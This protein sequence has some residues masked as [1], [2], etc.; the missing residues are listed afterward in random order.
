MVLRRR[1][2]RPGR[3]GA[4]PRHGRVRHGTAHV[5]RG[6]AT[7]RGPSPPSCWSGA[8]GSTPSAP[9]SSVGSAGRT[10]SPSSCTTGRSTSRRCS[11]PTGPAPSLSTSTSTT[12]PAEISALLADV[13]VKA[14]VYHRRYGPLV[15]MAIAGARRVVLIDVDDGSG[16][17]PL[18][19]S[20]DF[21]EL[22]SHPGR[23]GPA[24]DL[25]RRSLPGLH[26]RDHGTAQGGALAPGRHLRLGDG[27]G[28]GCHRRDDRRGGHHRDGLGPS[29]V[30]GGAADA[31]GG[32]VDRLLRTEPGRHRGACTTTA[33][34]SMRGPSSSWPSVSRWR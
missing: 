16:V 5:R 25:A 4:R 28:R 1:A 12:G 34:R 26:R 10:R 27:R 19:G 13:G 11:A 33:A 8:S 32:P 30:S 31:R 14:V 17:A 22:P 15:E 18:P 21:E 7:D 2:R 9:I 6:G 24:R 29:V 20:T 23:P 3:H